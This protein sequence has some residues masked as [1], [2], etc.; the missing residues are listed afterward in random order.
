MPHPDVENWENDPPPEAE[1]HEQEQPRGGYEFAPIDS[2]TFAAG[3][4]RP[5]WL[6]KR[7]LVRDQPAIVGG[8]KKVLKTSLLVDLA[9]SLATRTD[10]LGTFTIY[11]PVRVA[12]ISG[13]SGPHT[14]QETALRVCAA[15]GIDLADAGVLWDF[16]LPQLSSLLDMGRLQEG[17][18]TFGVETI[19]I[20]PL[21]LALLTGVGA[22]G[23][24]ASSLYD[25]GPLLLSIARACLSVGCTP[26]LIHH[27]R[28][29]QTVKGAPLELEDL[30]F[31]GVAEF[32]RQ[33]LL[34][35]RREEYQPGTGS[36]HLWLSAGGSIG[37]GGLWAVDVEEGVI[38]ENFEG[39]RWDVTVKS[40]SEESMSQTQARNDAVAE[41]EAEKD[42]VDDAAILNVLREH[43]PE[44]K[45]MSKSKV[46]DLSKR[47][48][49]K[50]TRAIA[51]LVKDGLIEELPV[52]V[53]TG[54]S[55]RSVEGIR[56][57]PVASNPATRT[58]PDEPVHDLLSEYP[59][60][61]THTTPLGGVSASGFG[62]GSEQQAMA[63]PIPSGLEV[64]DESAEVNE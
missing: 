44:R 2:A 27:A 7:L 40:S 3:D 19:I 60:T 45:G 38:N 18:E 33:W 6:I 59:V 61:R 22:E 1:E 34:I 39:R 20:D 12:V 35:S 21:Y 42:K 16:K 15:K 43:D 31:A 64:H 56:M 14:L 36:H 13:E 58:N 46:R 26:I 57:P 9:I 54:N 8:P 28:K 30:A 4:Y 23:K 29:N 49:P 53:K 5:T 48:G 25:M 10:F 55:V 62:H 52:D 37:H 63:D 50:V 24:Q 17:L 11:K 32:A 47:G 41:R 51:R